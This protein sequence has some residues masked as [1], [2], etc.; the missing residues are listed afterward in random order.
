VREHDPILSGHD[1]H[2]VA[3]DLFRLIV[4]GDPEPLRQARNVCV[5]NNPRGYSERVSENDIGGLARYA[6]K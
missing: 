5:D 4:P 6:G 3:L 1:F 2:Q